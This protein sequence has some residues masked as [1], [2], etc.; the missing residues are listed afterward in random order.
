MAAS[1]ATAELIRLQDKFLHHLRPCATSANA[2]FGEPVR[3]LPGHEQQHFHTSVLFSLGTLAHLI[4]PG[5]L[6]IG[7]FQ[8]DLALGRPSRLA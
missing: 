4:A 1:F 6:C 3:D 2:E 7:G 5:S 8:S